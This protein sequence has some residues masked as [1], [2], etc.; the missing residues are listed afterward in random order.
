[1]ISRAD[2]FETAA[3]NWG[4]SFAM[5]SVKSVA[6]WQ[7]RGIETEAKRGVEQVRVDPSVSVNEKAFGGEPLRAVTGSFGADSRLP[8]C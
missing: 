7:A 8:F 5:S 4:P 3:A 6:S 2:V 1:L